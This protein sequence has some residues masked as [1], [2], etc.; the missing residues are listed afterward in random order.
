MAATWSTQITAV[1]IFSSFFVLF[2]SIPII[3][4]R[5]QALKAKYNILKSIKKVE[6]TVETDSSKQDVNPECHT[7]GGIAPDE[8]A[9]PRVKS[10]RE[11]DE[12]KAKK[13]LADMKSHWK[14]QQSQLKQ[15]KNVSK[16][17]SSPTLPIISSSSVPSSQ[18][19][20]NV[21][22]TSE[23]TASALRAQQDAEYAQA[24][25]ETLRILAEKEFKAV[26]M[27]EAQRSLSNSS[28]STH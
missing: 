3:Y 28:P 15:G 25:W 10:K 11:I 7:P 24:E 6:D 9:T 27:K 2:H 14:Q 16:P 5:F 20:A 12:T 8:T 23:T 22:S 26:S 19:S 17:K 13:V 1:A 18:I 21:T 4:H